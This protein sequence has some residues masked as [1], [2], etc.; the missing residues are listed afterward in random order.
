[1]TWYRVSISSSFGL[2]LQ[3][4]WFFQLSSWYDITRIYIIHIYCV[5]IC[6]LS[7]FILSCATLII[8]VDVVLY[9]PYSSSTPEI[10]V[11]VISQFVYLVVGSSGSCR[12]PGS[13]WVG[14]FSSCVCG[15]MSM[16]FRSIVTFHFNNERKIK[17]C[18]SNSLVPV[19]I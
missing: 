14:I 8:S 12:Y 13:S 19:T 3:M 16:C 1:M 11:I 9:I 18:L 7:L 6:F 10:Y 17:T 5:A 2:S 15:E 4:I